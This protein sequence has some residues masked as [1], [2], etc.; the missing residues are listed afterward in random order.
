M[1]GLGKLGG[2][3]EW[4]G[5]QPPG[6]NPSPLSFEQQELAVEI[7]TINMSDQLLNFECEFLHTEK[8]E[9]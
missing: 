8:A 5:V 4:C 2:D 3:I 1:P 9:S 6:W 7:G